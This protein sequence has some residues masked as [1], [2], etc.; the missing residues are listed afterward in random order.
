ME[1]PPEFA[2]LVLEDDDVILSL[3]RTVL[4][5]RG[6]KVLAA[7]SAAA[8]QD[9]VEGFAGRIPLAF[10][11]VML[12]GTTGPRFIRWLRSRRAAPRVI[13]MSG[14]S[15]GGLFAPG[16]LSPGDSFLAKPFGLSDILRIVD[17]SPDRV[18]QPENRP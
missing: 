18:P 16:D 8:A 5:E 15:P 6:H 12:R 14:N 17:G 2:I 10:C 1:T 4:E 11:D 3:L 7:A 13:Y 9:L